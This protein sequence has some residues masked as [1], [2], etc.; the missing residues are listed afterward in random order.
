M[1]AGASAS[2][3]VE[4]SGVISRHGHGHPAPPGTSGLIGRGIPPRIYK[5]SS[6]TRPWLVA[7]GRCSHNG[8]GLE[9][10]LPG[11]LRTDTERAVPPLPQ[12]RPEITCHAYGCS[13]MP[14]ALHAPSVRATALPSAARPI[15][16]S[17]SLVTTVVP[18]PCW[19][20]ATWLRPRNT[21]SSS[22]LRQSEDEERHLFSPLPP[23][24]D[25]FPLGLSP[26][27]LSPSAQMRRR[28]GSLAVW[29]R[30]LSSSPPPP[31]AIH[32]VCSAGF[33][34]GLGEAPQ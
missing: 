2:L 8:S 9:A 11:S 25:F 3:T 7:D 16:S 17:S 30:V 34:P 21:S 28:G 33:G 1:K 14:A 32:Q 29:G 5:R 13:A 24:S 4:G 15:R 27:G 23:M 22:A 10:L 26:L 19:S 6:S 31:A 20:G 12:G 18:P